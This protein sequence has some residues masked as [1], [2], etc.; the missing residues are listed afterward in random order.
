VKQ[1]WQACVRPAPVTLRGP[2]GERVHSAGCGG[3]N[4]WAKLGDRPINQ[5]KAADFAGG[6]FCLGLDG[7]WSLNAGLVTH[8]TPR[9]L[10]ASLLATFQ[11]DIICML[12]V[13][14]AFT[15]KLSHIIT[16][17]RRQVS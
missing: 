11:S 3:G 1:L 15:A 2:E 13:L 4:L 5:T 8:P 6:I 14:S 10:L 7:Y 17:A 16:A 9:P 12:R